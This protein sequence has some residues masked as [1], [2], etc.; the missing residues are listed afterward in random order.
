PEALVPKQTPK[1]VWIWKNGDFIPWDEAKVHIMSLAV[2]FGS[3]VFEGIRCY[4]TAQGP[5]IF[6]LR[7]HLR[8][9]QD[10]CRIYRMDLDYTLDQLIEASVSVVER[11]GF[12]SCYVRPMVLK[13]IGQG[14]NPIGIDTD[15]YIVT[16]PWGTYLG[17]GALEN[18]VDA[19]VSNWQRMEPNTFPSMAKAAGH[20]NNA[21]L[22]K[23]DA[24]SNGYKEAV[25]LGP[26]GLV[27]EGS[28]EN[29]FVVKNG[30]LLTPVLDGT[31]LWG[32]TRDTVLTIAREMEIPVREQPIPRE[33]L[34]V[35][36]EVFFCGT[37][38]EVTPARSM[39]KIQIGDGR[40]GP[41]TKRIQEKF[42]AT[43]RGETPD[44]HGWLTLVPRAVAAAS[45]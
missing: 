17:D 14:M 40:R 12:E 35:A 22:I 38:A 43:V 39:D 16:F 27:S 37:A 26:G 15:V 3:S 28:G 9:L 7:D 10:S 34:Y 41:I 36:D 29:V 8:R 13:G 32:I 33:L 23:M 21:Q 42:L 20:Y 44:R 11:N 1:A 2:Q 45:R 5:A 31:E 30:L 6:R 18:G 4:K 24:V 19:C 25:A